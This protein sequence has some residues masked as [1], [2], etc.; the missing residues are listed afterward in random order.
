[1]D[2]GDE[3]LV[4]DIPHFNDTFVKVLFVGDL[5]GD[6]NLDFIFDTSEHYGQKKTYTYLDY[7]F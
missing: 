2:G 3:Q 6:G 5:D 1:M 7:S 4:L